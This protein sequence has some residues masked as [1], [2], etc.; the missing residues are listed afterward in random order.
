[1]SSSVWCRPMF[2]WYKVNFDAYVPNYPIHGLGVVIHNH[3]GSLVAAGVRRV[4]ASRVLML[5]RLRQ[6]LLVWSWPL[7]LAT[8]EFIWKVI[9]CLS[10]LLSCPSIM[11]GTLCTFLLM[12]LSLLTLS[13]RTFSAVMLV[14]VETP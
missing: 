3:S 5:V 2:G 12:K 11:N 13:F 4:K 14:V 8:L 7:D 10:S 1:M 6:L 9:L